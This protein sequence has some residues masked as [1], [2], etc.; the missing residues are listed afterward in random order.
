MLRNSILSVIFHAIISLICFAVYVWFFSSP[1]ISIIALN[2]LAVIFFIVIMLTYFL[3]GIFLTNQGKVIKNIL[4]VSALIPLFYTGLF[5]KIDPLIMNFYFNSLFYLLSQKVYNENPYTNYLAI[6][7]MLL[8][9]ILMWA[10]IEIFKNR[11]K[12]LSS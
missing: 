4:S 5:L 8:P 10:G 1:G 11:T 12:N 7:S 3:C 6:V 2:I 9:T